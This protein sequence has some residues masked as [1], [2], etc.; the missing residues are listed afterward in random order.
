MIVKTFVTCTLR[1]VLPVL[2]TSAASSLMLG[3]SAPAA[4]VTARVAWARPSLGH[5]QGPGHNGGA[6]RMVPRFWRRL[7]V[8]PRDNVD[9]SYEKWMQHAFLETKPKVF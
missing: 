9:K 1:H 8:S 4:P 3:H 6:A 7:R 5:I 2:A